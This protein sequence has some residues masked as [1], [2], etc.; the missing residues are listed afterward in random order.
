MP[1]ALVGGELEIGRL[2]RVLELVQPAGAHDRAGDRGAGSNPRDGHVHGRNAP[3]RGQFEEEAHAARVALEPV[4]DALVR[5]PARV[6]GNRPARLI[7]PG[8]QPDQQRA[9]NR[10]GGPFRER[11]RQHFDLDAALDRVVRHLVADE[12]RP[13]VEPGDRVRVA[14]QPGRVVAAAD[15]ARLAGLHDAVQRL[16]HLHRLHAFFRPVDHVEIHEVR[17]ESAQ[18]LLQ[19]PGDRLGVNAA[20]HLRRQEDFLARGLEDAAEKFLGGAFA[21]HRGGVNEIHARV[22]RRG[23]D[24]ARLG[25]VGAPAEH[26]RAETQ[27]RDLHA[28]FSE[29]HLFHLARSDPLKF[30]SRCVQKR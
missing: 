30:R 3:P 7:F 24:A 9:V 28:G 22:E 10:D 16:H 4:G 6:L 20:V 2:E 11:L 13:A 15:E 23:D 27:V 19:A 26:H 21:V 29:G 18:A 8:Q 12:F 14:E 25:L 5:L 1:V 17:L